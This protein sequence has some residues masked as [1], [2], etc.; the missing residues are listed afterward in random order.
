MVRGSMCWRAS[1]HAVGSV[2]GDVGIT[3]GCTQAAV[4]SKVHLGIRVEE[5]QSFSEASFLLYD[6]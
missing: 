1:A 2:L 4:H 5:H 6:N 3:H